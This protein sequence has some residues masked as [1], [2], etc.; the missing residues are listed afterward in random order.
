MSITLRCR[1][2]EEEH[3]LRTSSRLVALLGA[4]SLIVAACGGS[5]PTASPATAAPAT[6]APTTA[7]ATAAPASEAPTAAPVAWKACMVTDTA[8][9]NDKSFNENAW[10]G[11]TDAEAKL[12]IEVK[13]LESRSDA[14]YEKNINQFLSEGCNIIVATDSCSVTPRRPLP[15]RTRTPASR[16]S[17][18]PTI[19][20]S[21]TSRASS[22]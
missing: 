21:R 11:L 9:I 14:D 8:G 10:K 1:D 18:S 13:Y 17:T 15:R 2:N 3:T 12:G 7:P 22:T 4:A 19:R 20:R 5:T 6:A 16:S